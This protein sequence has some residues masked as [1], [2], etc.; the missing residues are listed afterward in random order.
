MPAAKKK[1][2]RL[3]VIITLVLL[4]GLLLGLLAIFG[5]N[6]KKEKYLYI[7][8]GADYNRVLT[9]LRD[10]GYIIDANSFDFIARQRDLPRHVRPG[11]Y[12]V[13]QGMSNYDLVR[14]L[15]NGR[16]TPVKLVINKIRT[17]E[18]FIHLLSA[19]LEPDSAAFA[20]ILCDNDFLSKFGVD[21]QTMMCAVIPATYELYWNTGAENAFKKIQKS[22]DLFWTPDR[23]EQAQ[24]RGL[25]PIRATIVASIIEEETNKTDDKPLIA[26]VYLNRLT[27]G[28]K[29]QAD[30]TV[31]FAIGDFTIRRITGPMLKTESPYNT[32]QHEGLPPGPICTPSAATIDAVLQSPKTSFIFFCA[33]A[34]L[35]GASVFAST[36]EEHLKNAALYQKALNERGI[37]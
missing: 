2:S 18:D 4:A 1:K 7:H 3:P 29:L 36:G 24:S 19:N 9:T 26:S 6:G 31:K 23:K 37:H 22:Y 28:M 13:K 15:R 16:Q 21:S 17:R 30:P 11:K 33:K 20:Q 8:T 12:L 5:P 14:M 10:S 32:Y 34:D 35:S 25:S 27:K